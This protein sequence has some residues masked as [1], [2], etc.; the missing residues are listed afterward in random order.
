MHRQTRIR[1]SF[2]AL[3]FLGVLLVTPPVLLVFNHPERILG[4]PA[5]YLYLFISWAALIALTALLA[6]RLDAG[7]NAAP[8]NPAGDG[9]DA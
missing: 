5:L 8:D 2:I 6:G 1:D 4:V 9:R 3:F 7:D